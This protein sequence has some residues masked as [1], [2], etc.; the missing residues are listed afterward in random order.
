MALFREVFDHPPEGREEGE[1]LWQDGQYALTLWTVAVSSGWNEPAL[2][3]LLRRGLRKDVQTEL[4]CRD[5]TL[6][7]DALITMAIHLDNLIREHRHLHQLFPSFVDCSESE[8]ESMEIGAT[9]L[10]AAERRLHSL[11]LLLKLVPLLTAMSD[12][13]QPGVRE[14]RGMAP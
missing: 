14:S 8:P 5:D 12:K 3:T 11:S 10:P 6:S 9:C 7:L 1:H 2:R 4:A 13:F